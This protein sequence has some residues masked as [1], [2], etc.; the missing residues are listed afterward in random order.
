MKILIDTNLVIPAEPTSASDIT[1]GTRMV[2]LMLGEASQGGHEV[3]VHPNIGR[4]LQSDTNRD[5][6]NARTALLKKYQL[7]P[8]PQSVPQALRNILGN[9]K[10][11]SHDE[12]D[13]ELLA[14]LFVSEVDFLVTEDVGIHKKAEKMEMADKVVTIDEMLRM[15]RTWS[16]ERILTLPAVHLLTCDKLDATDPIF[17]S[18]R[19][20]YTKASFDGWMA[21]CIAEQRHAWVIFRAG[22][23]SAIG[24]V[25]H[26]S[27]GEHGFKGLVLKI[28]TFKIGELGEGR[29]DSELLL[30]DLLSFAFEKDYDSAYLEILPKQK[31]LV[32]LLRKFGFVDTGHRTVR[33]EQ[34]FQKRLHYTADEF[35][36]LSNLEF[37]V[38]FGPKYIKVTG[39]QGY[40]IPIRPDFH[41]LLFPDAQFQADLIPGQYPFGNAI[42]K[43]YLCRSPVKEI[44]PG[45]L[46][47][48][49]RSGD[50]KAVR[51]VG[52]AERSIRSSD[53]LEI[54]RFVSIRT[55]YSIQDIELLAARGQVLCILFRHARVLPTPIPRRDLIRVKILTSSP[56][57]I[58]RVGAEGM[59]W[60]CKTLQL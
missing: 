14:S 1:A 41:K 58:I 32:N 43:A 55:V 35:R 39:A 29:G 21:K 54:L 46:L 56:Q 3:L 57:S 25:K 59:E 2:S 26:E 33:S 19:D 18:L 42:R 52:V 37:H 30:R 10:P 9:P 51:C 13:D 5:R 12:V 48:F 7:L 16:A 20:D 17:D 23:Y 34:V 44:E 28:C 40:L 22:G 8:N 38:K 36:D 15:I 47:L 6:R 45:S 4:D 11:G 27:S 53:A 31:P 24:I 60:L 49:Y 50:E